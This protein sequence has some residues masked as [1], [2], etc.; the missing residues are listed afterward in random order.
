M[1]SIELHGM[2]NIQKA[3]EKFPELVK[4]ARGEMFEDLGWELLGAVRRKIGGSGRV[5]GAQEYQVGS[6]KGYVAVRAEADTYLGGYAA[7][8]VT[9]ALENGHDQTPGRY[10][11]AL[12]RTL[13][14]TRVS[15]RYMYHTVLDFI[16]PGSAETASKRLQ[17]QIMDEMF[18]RSF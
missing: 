13:L 12:G 15:G 6:G 4:K 7:G 2:K 1:Q 3:L 8:Y 17:K 9:N 11:P 14:R 18:G 10:V 16:A 5:A